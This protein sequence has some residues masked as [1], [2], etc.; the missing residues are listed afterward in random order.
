MN[1]LSKLGHH[2]DETLNFTSSNNYTKFWIIKK[3][4]F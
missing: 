3:S 4:Y 1:L 2:C